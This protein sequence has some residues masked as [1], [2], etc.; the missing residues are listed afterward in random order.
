M[1]PEFADA[2]G[3]LQTLAVDLDMV[4]RLDHLDVVHSHT[5]YTNFAGHV[6][7]EIFDIPHVITAH[8][9]EPRRPWKAEQLGGG[10]RTSSWIKYVSRSDSDHRRFR[11]YAA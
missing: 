6:A 3:A 9:L 10:Y 5:W 11:R 2:N 1:P 8:S 7:G 4:R